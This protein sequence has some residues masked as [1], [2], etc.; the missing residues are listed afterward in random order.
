ML[1]HALLGFYRNLT[2]H[3]LYSALNILGLATGIAVFLVLAQV[4][5]YEYSFDRWLP[6][7]DEIYR[8]DSR[9][10]LPGM[11][12]FENGGSSFVILDLLRADYPQIAARHAADGPAG[13]R[14]DGRFADEPGR[15]VC[16]SRV[17]PGLRL[18]AAAWRPVHRPD[19]AGPCPAERAHGAPPVRQHGCAGAHAADHP[20][21]REAP[22]H[23]VRHPSRPCRTTGASTSTSWRRSARW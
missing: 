18:A 22:L 16:R 13:G 10:S 8:L 6:H 15:H 11:V 20:S 5:R 12:P 3:K 21:R 14:L 17:S 1:P 23:R 9:I 2:R 4:V 19:R 7:A